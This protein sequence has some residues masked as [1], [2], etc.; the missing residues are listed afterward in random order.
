MRNVAILTYG[1]STVYMKVYGMKNSHSQLGLYSQIVVQNVVL[2]NV[3]GDIFIL[4][5]L[6]SI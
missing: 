4:F 2:I 1:G 3:V 5:L 6:F